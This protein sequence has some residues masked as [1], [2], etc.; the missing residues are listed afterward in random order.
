MKNVLITGASGFVG[1]NLVE[2]LKDRYKLFTPRHTQLEL[3][4]YEA[5]ESYVR[6]NQIDVIVHGA[7]HVPMV[8]GAQNE[9][10]NDMKMFLNIEKISHC[11]EKVLYFGSGA[12]YNKCYDL[13]MVQEEDIGKIIPN[14][15]YGLAKYTMNMIA[16]QSANIY[17]LRL[18]GIFGPYELWDV[19]FL[20]NICC[21]AV[22]NLPLTVRKDCTFDFLYIKDLPD[23]AEWFIE[24]KPRYHDYNVCMGVQYPLSQLASI[25]R[26]ISGKDLTITLLSDERNK[27]YSASNAR[28]KAE[29]PNL[30]ITKMEEALK[31]L[32][33]YYQENK[34]II[35]LDIL[36]GSR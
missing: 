24:N 36:K 18:F 26:N 1:Q 33:Y 19:K 11:I 5:L 35:D 4:D 28:L 22:Y 3:L 9:F 29:I 17:N 15:E 13:S 7:V 6:K 16:R 21:K 27:D 14:S 31:E 12:E 34:A 32:Y 20:S 10:Y 25:V 23:I 2:A 8:N 30:H